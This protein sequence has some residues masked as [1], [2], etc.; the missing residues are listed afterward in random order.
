MAYGYSQIHYHSSGSYLHFWRCG[1]EMDNYFGG[2]LA[3]ACT[4]GWGLY[5][6]RDQK[7]GE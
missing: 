2:V 5:L 1:T 6:V 3:V 4:L 7:K